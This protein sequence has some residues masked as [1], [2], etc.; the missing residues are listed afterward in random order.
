MWPFRDRFPKF[1]HLLDQ[2]LE[3]PLQTILARLDG[4]EA[5]DS[6]SKTVHLALEGLTR[7]LDSLRC[8]SAQD[9][10]QMAEQLATLNREWSDAQFELDKTFRKV[11][12]ELGYINRAKRTES[13]AAESPDSTH[14]SQVPL[15]LMSRARLNREGGRS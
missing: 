5:G 6:T 1:A 11:H 12:S 3:K 2:S 10:T 9:L 8:S 7:E 15:A 4:L 14:E 13:D